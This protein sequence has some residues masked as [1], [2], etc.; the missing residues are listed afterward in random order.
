M[1]ESLH[2]SVFVTVWENHSNAFLLFHSVT[3]YEHWKEMFSF[4]RS[5]YSMTWSLIPSFFSSLHSTHDQKYDRCMKSQF[6]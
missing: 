4:S 5:M 2:I 6:I 3:Y 1:N